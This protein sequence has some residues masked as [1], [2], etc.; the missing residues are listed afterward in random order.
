[1]KSYIKYSSICA[2]FLLTVFFTAC[3]SNIEEQQE[4]LTKV[5]FIN[6]VKPIM[7]A[8]CLSCHGAGGNFPELK[9]YSE[10]STHAVIVKEEVASGRMPRGAALTAAQIKSIVDWVD[11]GA[12]DN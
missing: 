10:V 5:S 7:D 2:I 4:E 6:D 1:M 12:L 11:E 8:R 9:N 3:I